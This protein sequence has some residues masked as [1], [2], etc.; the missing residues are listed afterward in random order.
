MGKAG[1][2]WQFFRALLPSTWRTLS[3]DALF[4]RI[5]DT[6]KRPESATF[7]CFPCFSLLVSGSTLPRNAYFS[8]QTLN[9]QIVP[10]LPS[11]S[12]PLLLSQTP[13][14]QDTRPWRTEIAAIFAICVC[15]MPVADP[16]NRSDFGNNTKQCCIS[17]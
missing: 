14:E 9:C 16:R 13:Q 11:Y 15:D 1:T 17:I 3:S 2:I 6:R 5:W 4:T 8:W 7:S 10:V 12:A